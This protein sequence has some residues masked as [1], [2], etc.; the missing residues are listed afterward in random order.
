MFINWYTHTQIQKFQYRPT[1]QMIPHTCNIPRSF[2]SSCVYSCS[3]SCKT[4]IIKHLKTT[5]DYFIV[6]VYPRNKASRCVPRSLT[7]HPIKCLQF[8]YTFSVLRKRETRL[9][10]YRRRRL[11]YRKMT[12]TVITLTSIVAVGSLARF[13]LFWM[14]IYDKKTCCLRYGKM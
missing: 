1:T 2:S 12:V 9:V 10:S 13:V 11:L 3:L 7:M 8:F 14:T 5:Q 6:C 4:C